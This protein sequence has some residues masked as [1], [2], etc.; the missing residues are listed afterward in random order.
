MPLQRDYAAE[1]DCV[2]RFAE[3][4]DTLTR[5]RELCH[6]WL[7]L[8][9]L[10]SYVLSE[11]ESRTYT[12]AMQRYHRLLK[13][14]QAFAGDIEYLQKG[15]LRQRQAYAQKIPP[16]GAGQEPS[17]REDAAGIGGRVPPACG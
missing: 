5:L 6:Q 4:S 2:R 13:D 14:M 16:P 1:V 15:F 10:A 17:Q 11:D 8:P 9:L 3:D 7:R 12:E